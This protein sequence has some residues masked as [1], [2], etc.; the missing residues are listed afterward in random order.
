Q[1]IWEKAAFNAVLNPL[2]TLTLNPVGRVGAY[3]S[4]MEVI[5]GILNEIEEIAEAEN[6]S[7]HKEK[8]RSVIKSV[9]DPKMSAHHYSSMYYDIHKGRQTEIDYLNGAV[10]QKGKEHD[11]P[12]PMNTLLFHLIKM[13]ETKPVFSLT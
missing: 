7:F 13:L 9:F 10:A 1:S 6:I 2:C 4:I 11:I 5:S 12:V 3:E 8:V